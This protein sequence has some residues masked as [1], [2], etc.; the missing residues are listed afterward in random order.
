MVQY[1]VSKNITFKRPHKLSYSCKTLHFHPNQI[2][3]SQ[4]VLN[5]PT[6][7]NLNQP[8]TIPSAQGFFWFYNKFT[9]CV[10]LRTKTC[11]VQFCAKCLVLNGFVVKSCLYSYDVDFVDKSTILAWNAA[12]D[13]DKRKRQTCC[14]VIK[15]YFLNALYPHQNWTCIGPINVWIELGLDFQE[16]LW[17][18][19]DGSLITVTPFCLFRLDINRRNVHSV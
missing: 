10:E 4:V 11:S 13:V 9:F 14:A 18:G 2:T 7:L 12:F 3:T 17:I 15:N 5:R 19:L 1:V 16:T 6:L 8:T